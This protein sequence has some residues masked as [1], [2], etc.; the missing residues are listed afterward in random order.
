MHVVD[1]SKMGILMDTHETSTTTEYIFQDKHRTKKINLSVVKP[2]SDHLHIKVIIFKEGEHIGYR[3]HV[4]SQG[5]EEK[6]NDEKNKK[7]EKQKETE[8]EK[9]KEKKRM[10]PNMQSILLD[11]PGN[12][13]LESVERLTHF[14]KMHGFQFKQA[15]E[16]QMQYLTHHVDLSKVTHMAHLHGCICEQ[17]KEVMGE[18]MGMRIMLIYMLMGNLLYYG[19]D[20]IV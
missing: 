14:F 19:M 13:A 5:Q 4:S 9:E 10:K 18:G 1:H 12:P 15:S 11:T 16:E 6:K 2:L 3:I 20:V 17:F 8:S 7:S